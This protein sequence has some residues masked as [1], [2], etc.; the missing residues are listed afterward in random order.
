MTCSTALMLSIS[1][2]IS[3]L[4]HLPFA[5]HFHPPTCWPLPT[6]AA[7][8][9]RQHPTTP[10]SSERSAPLYA[11]GSPPLDP[12]PSSSKVSSRPSPV[13]PQYLRPIIPT[14]LFPVLPVPPK[15]STDGT[16]RRPSS[17]PAPT[18][19]APPFTSPPCRR[20]VH[21][22]HGKI[23]VSTTETGCVHDFPAPIAGPTLAEPRR[24]SSAGRADRGIRRKAR[25]SG[26][27]RPKL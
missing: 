9:P 15:S 20:K 23:A 2:R 14:T 18:P 16:P 7:A 11:F 12:M 5:M 24:V 22:I 1:H 8:S 3:D 4:S 17:S 26:G 21:N 13:P 6:G 10:I 19:I 25:R 27:S